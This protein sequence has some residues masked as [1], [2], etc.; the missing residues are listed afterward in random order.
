[1]EMPRKSKQYAN[2]VKILKYIKVAGSWR[3][4][5]VVERN[6]KIVRDHVL[7]S[8]LDER[9]PEGTYYIEWYE[10]GNRRRRK[11]V[12]D[13]AAVVEEARRKAIEVEAVRAGVVETQSPPASIPSARLEVGVAIG[14][15]L[16]FVKNHRSPRTYLTYRYTLNILFRQSCKTQ[17]V[18]DVS[19]GDILEFMTY[20]Y[21]QGLGNLV[22]GADVDV[23]VA[24]HHVYLL[25]PGG[26]LE[27]NITDR[28]LDKPAAY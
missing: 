7:I 14:S 26:E 25:T 3:F 2:R 13:F 12:L 1:M 28:D 9:H 20:C 24:H 19:R 6:G 27:T 8:G 18:E 17:S 21:T 16:E 10:I 5:N 11:A 23:R 4:A 15:H 22:S